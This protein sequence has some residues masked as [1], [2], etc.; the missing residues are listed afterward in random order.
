MA[1]DP[2]LDCF[3]GAT[4]GGYYHPE[5]DFVYQEMNHIIESCSWEEAQ[6]NSDNRTWELGNTSFEIDE[7]QSNQ[8]YANSCNED[9]GRPVIGE[10]S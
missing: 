9:D 2:E 10:Y 8:E 6:F 3:C 1:K 7:Y 5:D 4:E